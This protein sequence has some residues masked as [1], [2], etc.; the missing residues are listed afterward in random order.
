MDQ[1]LP[2]N[3]VLITVVVMSAVALLFVAGLAALL[4]VHHQRRVRHRAELAE[5]ALAHQREVMQAEREATQHTLRDV[6][7]ELHD[8]VGQLLSVAQ[9]GLNIALAEEPGNERL[10]GVRDAADRAVEEVRRLGHTLNVDLWRERS[11]A[12]AIQVE[13][14]RIARVSRITVAV[15]VQGE[16]TEPPPDT[17][18]ILFRVFQEVVNNALKHSG[19]DRITIQLLPVGDGLKATIADNG[20]GFD[21]AQVK[22]NAGLGNIRQRCL[23]VNYSAHCWTS[24]G[25]GCTWTLEPL[26]IHDPLHRPGR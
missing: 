15:E 12:E 21:Q 17:C 14:E 25:E 24:P 7:R 1:E 13:A 18:T 8:N 6:G 22:A 10:N 19:A 2:L 11:L 20:R 23:L 3:D 4:V 9:M 26:T 16:P 5:L